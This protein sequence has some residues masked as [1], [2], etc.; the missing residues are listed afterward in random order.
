MRTSLAT[1]RCRDL[2]APATLLCVMLAGC[3]QAPGD[4]AAP[5]PSATERAATL[6]PPPPPPAV[7]ASPG[8]RAATPRFTVMAQ[9]AGGREA[10]SAAFRAVLDS[11]VLRDFADQ[12]SDLVTMRRPVL[13]D[14]QGCGKPD[15]S[16]DGAND[17]LTICEELV[18]ELGEM[19]SAT[20]PRDRADQALVYAVALTFLHE[21]GHALVQQLEL[22]I[23]DDEEDVADQ[24]AAYILGGNP[25]ADQAAMNGAA[26]FGAVF[27]AP[28]APAMYWDGRALDAQRFVKLNCW[29][30]GSNPDGYAWLV[31]PR[32]VPA[33]RA[34]RCPSEWTR[35]ERSLSTLLAPHLK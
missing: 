22:T 13:V 7:R 34:T 6:P 15:A 18:H 8:A 26:W 23:A 30:L 31:G 29:V 35:L 10:A 16:Y 14:M 11:N 9:T 2:A 19:L 25:D 21:A 32:I 12:L 20:L 4:G 5:L 17:R 27:D 33:E 3:D 28:N 1:R 24:F